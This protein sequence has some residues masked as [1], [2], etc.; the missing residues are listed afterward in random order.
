MP[1]SV[2]TAPMPPDSCEN[3]T[4]L[5]SRVIT[6]PYSELCMADSPSS[7]GVSTVVISPVAGSRLAMRLV[8]I[9][10]NQ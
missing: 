3:H 7:L 1:V 8:P 4:R 9:S 2:L 6:A 10:V 5:P